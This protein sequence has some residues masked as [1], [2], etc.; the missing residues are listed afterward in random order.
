MLA[1]TEMGSASFDPRR[2][3][4]ELARRAAAAMAAGRAKARA[5]RDYARLRGL[6]DHLLADAGLSRAAID[7]AER[8]F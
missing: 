2:F 1:S 3:L 5:R 6:D 7:A 4:A 8:G